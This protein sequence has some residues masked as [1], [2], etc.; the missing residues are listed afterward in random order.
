[1]ACFLSQKVLLSAAERWQTGLLYMERL[2]TPRPRFQVASPTSVPDWRAAKTIFLVQ[3]AA[4]P[5]SP[6][7][8]ALLKRG[9]QVVHAESVDAALRTWVKLATPVDLF[10]ADI[11]LGRDPGIEQLVKFLQAENARMRVLY[12]NDLDD[13]TGPLLAQ[14]YPE[15][16]VTI[17]DNCLSH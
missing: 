11:S 4:R 16:L 9:Y 13:V 12:A 8:A 15:Q 17:I 5:G 7:K 14:S 1:M 6:V 10:L 2:S 3:S